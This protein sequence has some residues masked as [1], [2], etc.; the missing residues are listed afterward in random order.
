TKDE[1]S[2]ILKTFITELENQ[3]DHKVKVIRC[4]DGTE[5]KNSIMNQFYE[6]MGIKREFSVARTSQ[7]NGVAERK[8]RTLIETARTM[9]VDSKL[10]TTFWVEAVN[11]ACYV[12]NRVLVI[13]PHNK[14]PYEL[15]H[16]ITLLIDFIKPFG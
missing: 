9:L 14:T 13:K 6:M 15:I 2:G 4:D 1:T 10:L 16:G 12:L 7:Q 5:F 3:L 11:T 8:N